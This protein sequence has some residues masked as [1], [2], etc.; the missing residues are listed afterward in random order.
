[1]RINGPLPGD[2][3]ML[4]RA[5]RR[6]AGKTETFRPG[7]PAEETARAT[8]SVAPARLTSLD[9]LLAL[10]EEPDATGGHSK[11]LRRGADMLDLLDEIRLGLLTG[12]IPQARLHQLL[13]LLRGGRTPAED[14]RL[15]ALLDQIE[16]RAAVELA[17][18]GQYP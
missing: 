8:A 12:A 17:K 15:A 16:L 14:P 18:L 9:G 11:G 2:P 13:A 5:E 7:L 4:R 1:M 10:Q 3:A 6:S